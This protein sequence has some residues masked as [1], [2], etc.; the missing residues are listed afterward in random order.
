MHH[1]SPDVAAELHW[2]GENG[3]LWVMTDLR[4]E[5]FSQEASMRLDS[6]FRKVRL[7]QS[8]ARRTDVC[9]CECGDA[10]VFVCGLEESGSWSWPS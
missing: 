9:G 5:A 8:Q 7:S 4:P 3:G 6:I 10:A 1:R 2:G